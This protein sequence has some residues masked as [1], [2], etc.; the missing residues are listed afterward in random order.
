MGNWPNDFIAAFSAH[1]LDS[2]FSYFTDDM[3]YEEVVAN[4]AVAHGKQELRA[5]IQEMMLPAHSS[6]RNFFTGMTRTGLSRRSRS[7]S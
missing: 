1:D 3:F 2:V 4:G 7:P 5:R 6:A